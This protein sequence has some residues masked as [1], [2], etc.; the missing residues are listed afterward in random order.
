M[1]STQRAFMDW[2]GLSVP[3]LQAPIGGCATVELVRAVGQAG[4]LGSLACTWTPEA[5]LE[6]QLGALKPAHVPYFLNYVLRFG[7]GTLDAALR[8]RP[9][10]V[11]FSWGISAELIDAV[12][13]AGARAGVQVASV[14]GARAAIAAGAD[15]VIVQGLEAGGHVQSSMPLKPLLAGALAVSG[16]VPVVAAGGLACGADI[17]EVLRQGA[18]A[19]MMGTR[20][21]ATRE[22]DAHADY[23]Q[24]L[25]AA[26]SSDTAWTNCF[27]ID[28]P[29][30]MHRVLRNSTLDM[31]EAAGCPAAPNRPGEGDVVARHGSAAVR[32]YSDT[33]PAV[34]A[35]GD[36]LAACLYAGTGVDHISDAPPAAEVVNRLWA[37]T[38]RHL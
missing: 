18:A 31:W 3:I 17:A 37:D 19:V 28:W 23:K 32:R 12:K 13:S 1:S 16:A 30:A 10:A 11:T 5:D 14:A 15:F 33:S 29:Y 7:R 36:T 2:F 20:F 22:A 38:R 8:H 24:A 27:D 21:V 34:N 26:K 6:R 9:P 25:I 4:A 35:T